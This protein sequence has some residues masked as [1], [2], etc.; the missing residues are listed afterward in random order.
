MFEMPTVALGPVSAQGFAAYEAAVDA[1]GS[2]AMEE[3]LFRSIGAIAPIDEMFAFERPSLEAPPRTVLSAGAQARAAHRALLYSDRFHALD[4]LNGAF[5]RVG[6]AAATLVIRVQATDIADPIYRRACY[7]EPEFVEKLS[8]ARRRA[9]GWMVLSLF[10]RRRTGRFR[11]TELRQLVDLGRLLLP[12]IT[13]HDAMRRRG[14]ERPLDVG[15]LEERLSGLCFGMTDRERAVCART[16][17]GMTAEAIGF[18]LGI[19]PT[20]VLTYR[21]RAYRRLNITSAF[22]LLGLLLH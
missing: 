10:R 4:P 11:E 5:A 17:S 14:E 12:M 8:I 16:V 22:Q 19:K 1:L 2:Q 15:V 9:S 7:S 21:R 18:D 13:R 3:V 20:S 6:S